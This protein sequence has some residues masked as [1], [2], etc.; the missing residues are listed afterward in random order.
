MLRFLALI[1]LALFPVISANAEDKPIVLEKGSFVK[2][3]DEVNPVSASQ[4]IRDF[5]SIDSDSVLVFIDSPGGD[6]L[7]G[8]RMVETVRSAK[9]VRPSLRV[10][11][12]I[13]SAASMAFYFAQLACDERVLSET[14]IMMQH[15]ASLGMQGKWGEVQSR[16]QLV[17]QLIALLDRDTAARLGLSVEA[18]R[19]TIVNDWWLVGQVAINNKAADRLGSVTCSVA[20]TK[21]GEC[22]L[23]F[24]PLPKQE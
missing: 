24:F 4:F 1:V 7:S 19:S 9:A 12:Y 14:S 18:Y 21:A 2:F 3:I 22:P 5:L 15:Q 20:L 6:V 10:S 11:C 8:I 16:S 17:A 13:Q 23:V